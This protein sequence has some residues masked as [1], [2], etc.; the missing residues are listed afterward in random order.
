M[1]L[2]KRLLVSLL[3]IALALGLAL[4]AFAADDPAMPVITAQYERIIDLAI[5]KKH[6]NPHIVQSVETNIPSGD[7]IGYQWYIIKGGDT[8]A[9]PIEGATGNSYDVYYNRYSVGDKIF[10]I[11]YNAADSTPEEGPHRV[12]SKM[13][14]F[15]DTTPEPTWWQ[16]IWNDFENAIGKIN[17]SSFMR[18]VV[19]FF[20]ALPYILLWPFAW[21]WNQIMNLFA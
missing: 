4:P 20:V 6:P 5:L 15:V 18:S 13:T 2:L 16:R 14:T 7:P 12:Q 8:V 9:T 11:V 1:K 21:L 3:V 17:S 10:V 19:Y